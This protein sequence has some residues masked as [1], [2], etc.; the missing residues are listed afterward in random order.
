MKLRRLFFLSLV[1]VC[2]LT[3]LLNAQ[4]LPQRN[5]QVEKIVEEISTDNIRHIITQLVSFGT[6]HSLS[7]VQSETRGIGAARRWIKSE[8]E[9]YS[10]ESGGRLKVEFDSFVVDPKD[11]EPRY[12]SRVPR[13]TEI[14]NVVAT[15]P[16]SRPE[17]AGRI[18][19]VSGHYD[20]MCSQMMDATCDAPGADDDASGTAVAMELARVMSKYQFDA[21]LVFLCVAGEEQ[22]LIG[23]SHWARMAKEKHWNIPAMLNN[24]IVGNIRGGDGET[25]NQAVRVFSEG[26]P[27]NESDTDKRLREAVGGEND[28]SSRQLARYIQEIAQ[29]YLP[30]FEVQMIYRRDRYGRGGDHTSF[31][32]NGFAAVRF[33]EFHEDF[34]HQHQTPRVEN[35]VQMG[36]LPEF[37]STDYVAQVARVNAATLSSLALAPASPENVRFASARQTYD[38]ALHWS[39]NQEKNIAGYTIVWRETTSPVW[40]HSL[41]VGKVTAFVLNGLSKDNLVFGVRAVDKEGNMS[42]VTVSRP[43]APSRSSGS[44]E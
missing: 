33:S 31:N 11:L 38:T 22:G 6:R 14:V 41:F 2:G 40:Q 18:Y 10:K 21:T 43:P 1:F 30:F 42:P 9:K 4:P 19:V 5:P 8:M 15:L 7:D 44:Q 12:R 3:I 17:S 37:V 25:N 32:E 29:R 27:A 23:S 39:P 28:S 24:D 36:D 13:A 20:S 16:G 34:R 35:G 26:V